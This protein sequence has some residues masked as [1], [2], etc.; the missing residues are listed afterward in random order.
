MEKYPKPFYHWT[1]YKGHGGVD[2]PQNAYTPIRAVANGVISFSGWWN[3]N[4]GYTR[5]LLTDDG[6]KLMHC[7]LVNLNGPR[8]G[9]RVKAGDIIAYVGT[10]GHSTGNHLHH[11]IWVNGVKQ[12][13]DNYWKYI[14]KNRVISSG[15]GAGGGGT[16]PPVPKPQPEPI[17][18]KPNLA[19]LEEKDEMN[20]QVSI[21][22]GGKEW[23]LAHP[24]IGL[25]LSQY[26]YDQT[27]QYRSEKT[28]GGV[29]NTFRGFMVTTD[30]S[31]G[32]AWCRTYC[33]AYDN[34]PQDRADDVDY[35][36]GQ[37][38]A[39]RVSVET[40]RRVS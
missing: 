24:D 19:L 30:P 15:S 36:L 13:G 21:R 32:A 11:E 28:G 27:P 3:D 26:V 9:T 33:R 31:R 1:T 12:S 22:P 29:V 8:V 39:S 14:D 2:Y 37:A 38:E 20:P 7:H 34:K 16:T 10:T 23:T 25:D 4:A 35:K 18:E 6:I 5:T 40:H 17:P